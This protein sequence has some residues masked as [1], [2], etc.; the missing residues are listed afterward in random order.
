MFEQKQQGNQKNL[1]PGA[2]YSMLQV[3]KE[4]SNGLPPIYLDG[5]A[6][7]K[8][9][10]HSRS[11]LERTATGIFL[12]ELLSWNNNSYLEITGSM[13]NRLGQEE[14]FGGEEWSFFKEPGEERETLG[15]YCSQPGKGIELN[16]SV[17]IN[18]QKFFNQP[19]QFLLLVEPILRKY[20][21]LQW[22]ENQL[23]LLPG[24][25]VTCLPEKKEQLRQLLHQSGFQYALESPQVVP[26]ETNAYP[27]KFIRAYQPRRLEDIE[28]ELA[29]EK[30]EI[31]FL[32]TR[33]EYREVFLSKDILVN[34]DIRTRGEIQ[35]VI[36]SLLGELASVTT[37]AL[38][39]FYWE[40]KPED[41]DYYTD[42]WICELRWLGKSAKHSV[43]WNTEVLDK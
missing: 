8:T 11:S 22:R 27:P 26:K 20:G 25:K 21:L 30:A 1:P 43:I 28:A 13:E 41:D 40:V 9:F 34:K 42:H 31:S 24:F 32:L 16:Q 6:L 36:D 4:D 23:V 19:Y 12:G 15:W 39:R 18:Q 37:K 14:D 2:R 7:L 17:L 29:E 5:N 38:I 33:K 3:G 10:I 35:K